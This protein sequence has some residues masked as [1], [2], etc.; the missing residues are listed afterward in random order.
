M[1]GQTV[2]HYKILEKLGEGGM[3]VVYKARDTKLDRLVAIKFLP[4]HLATDDTAKKRFIREAKAASALEH[5]NIC[6]INE[7]DEAPEGRLFLV[8]P[9]YEDGT[10]HD[11]LVKGPLEIDRILEIATQVVSGLAKAHE[12]GIIHRDIKPGNIM[13][14][15][16]GSQ[17]KIMDFGLARKLDASKMTRTGETLGT[18]AYMS[19]EQALGK[20]VDHRT[21]I[22][23]FGVVLHEMLTGKLP[24][25]DYAEPALLYSIVNEDP[26]A[27]TTL[28][29]DVPPELERIVVKCLAKDPG[30]RYQT[31]ADL[32]ADLRRVSRTATE[33]SPLVKSSAA[34]K[35]GTK[36]LPWRIA[37][38]IIA[39]AIVVSVLLFVFNIG[40]VRDRI[41]SGRPDGTG[42]IESL[43]IL[44]FVNTGS[45]PDTEYLSD[46]IPASIMNSLS[47]MSNLRVVP[48]STV[49]RYKGRESDLTAVGRELNVGAI[50]TGQIRVRGEDINIRAELVDV[51]ND[52]QLWG[53]RYSGT[54][55]DILSLEQEIVM[56]MSE[57]LKLQLTGTDRDRLAEFSTESAEAHRLYLKGRYFWNK[58]TDEGFKN[59]I[60]YFQ[61]AIEKDP[62]FAL[63]YA[64][65]AD[66]YITLAAFGILSPGDAFPKAKAAVS[67]AL[68]I[69]DTLAEA[70]TALAF[71]IASYEWDWIGAE[72]EYKRAIEL[73]PTYAT[74]LHWYSF[75]LARMGL[76]DEVIAVSKRAV[77]LDPLS[78]MIAAN[79]GYWHF[80]LRQHEDSERVCLKAIEMDKNFAYAHFLLGLVYVQKGE[81]TIGIEELKLAIEL[82]NN[83]PEFV[84]FLGYAYAISGMEEEAR[85]ILGEFSDRAERTYVPPTYFAVIHGGLG[86]MDE[87][88]EWLEK[89]YDV[90]DY[91]L[92]FIS[93]EPSY[94]PIRDD[95]RFISLCKRLGLDPALRTPAPA[96]STESE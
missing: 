39:A 50:L 1:I 37:L 92:S 15:D 52:R 20:E 74:T 47:R 18:V 44:P 29:K 67:K 94:D 66:T 7:I 45:D 55:T 83:T 91:Y 13:L 87:A 5:P 51:I 26:E 32:I 53:D 82:S 64:G 27:I 70:H 19:P 78:L 3:G 10:L 61:E 59:A 9:C 12:K 86:E 72:R 65:L 95:E 40:K 11:R 63:A 14:A 85:I 49:F 16:R 58:R 80:V 34:S 35:S 2:S 75:H 22:W 30:E 71:I 23:S 76:V 60:R 54:L 8:M 28:R 42:H 33:R 25:Q 41:F 48:R 62:T 38:T 73:N 56:K 57:A 84:A 36:A 21:D 96:A 93:F 81:H 46:E 4:H 24:F 88:F 31:A 77:E 17:S 69:D 90:R 43:A 79:L 68:E 6:H 89:A